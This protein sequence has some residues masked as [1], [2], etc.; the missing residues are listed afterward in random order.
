MIEQNIRE[1][2]EMYE[3]LL[4]AGNAQLAVSFQAIA[5]KYFALSIAS[6]FEHRITKAILEY[7]ERHSDERRYSY[8]IIRIRAIERQYSKFFDWD[9]SNAH[10]FFAMFGQDCKDAFVEKKKQDPLLKSAE[11]DFI[12][13][14]R[15]RNE[16]VHEN[17]LTYPFPKT[18]EEIES[19]Y[20]SAD[21]FVRYVEEE[22]R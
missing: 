8:H 12:E 10:K 13:I 22:L 3:G 19:K 16:L 11:V 2:R 5:Q 6:F 7:A 9:L 21:Y 14:G 18:L 15:L 1:A 20:K 17:F 4:S